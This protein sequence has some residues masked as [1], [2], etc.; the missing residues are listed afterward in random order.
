MNDCGYWVSLMTRCLGW[1]LW[2]ELG[3]GWG[4]CRLCSLIWKLLVTYM[5]RF[6]AYFGLAFCIWRFWLVLGDD[7][8][9]YIVLMF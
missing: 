5:K 7:K 8:L 1:D 6:G 4:G 2:G 9:G 3:D